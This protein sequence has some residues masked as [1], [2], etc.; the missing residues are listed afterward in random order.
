MYDLENYPPLEG[1]FLSNFSEIFK[2]SPM[3]SVAPLKLI[4]FW[5]RGLLF[6]E[7]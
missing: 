4:V 1:G 2:S 5:F 7:I 3:S 6:G